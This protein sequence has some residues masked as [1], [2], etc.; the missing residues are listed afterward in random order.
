MS[1][2]SRHRRTPTAETPLALAERLRDA[3]RSIAE[4]DLRIVLLEA[5]AASLAECLGQ[6]RAPCP[7]NPPPSPPKV[8]RQKP[9]PLDLDSVSSTRCSTCTVFPGTPAGM[10]PSTTLTV[11]ATLS[12][13][14]NTSTTSPGDAPESPMTASPLSSRVCVWRRFEPLIDEDEDDGPKQPES[15]EPC[16]EEEDEEFDDSGGN[17]ATASDLDAVCRRT[18][19]LLK[20]MEA[21]L[22]EGGAGDGQKRAEGAE[23]R[24]AEAQAAA[25]AVAAAYEVKVVNLGSGWPWST[26]R[27]LSWAAVRDAAELAGSVEVREPEEEVWD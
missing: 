16:P 8:A 27:R 15:G 13:C 19:E 14:P 21:A 10:T 17:F 20:A 6:S 24:G 22:A 9:T 12:Q 5:H 18:E 1:P 4:K 2:A 25:A 7:P 26:D 11:V 3:E 23:S